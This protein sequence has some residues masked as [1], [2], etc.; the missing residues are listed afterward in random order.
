VPKLEAHTDAIPVAVAVQVQLEPRPQ[1]SLFEHE[2]AP[3]TTKYRSPM[4]EPQVE[5]I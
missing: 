5:M 2:Q 4:N 1:R 3:E